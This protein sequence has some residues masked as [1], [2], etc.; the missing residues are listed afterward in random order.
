VNP[1]FQWT[2]NFINQNSPTITINPQNNMNVTV[3]VSDQNGCITASG[4]SIQVIAPPTANSTWVSSPNNVVDFTNV[5]L[6]STTY[7]WD[8]GDGSFGTSENPS[9]TYPSEGTW[10][11]T[12]IAS[13]AGCSDTFN[14]VVNSSVAAINSLD[15]SVNLYPNPV[16]QSLTIDTPE[17]LALRLFDMSGKVV[18][19]TFQIQGKT[20]LDL[21]ELQSGIYFV[22]LIKDQQ[23]MVQ[24]IVKE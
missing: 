5:S 11:V 20:Q 23:R 2:P 15:W 16:Q 9:H 3:T 18:I 17:N 6:N 8:F 14:L 24:R 21:S 19:P 7:S 22:E 10:N 13:N 4:I 12:L 1:N